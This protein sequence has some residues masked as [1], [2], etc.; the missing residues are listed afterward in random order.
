MLP[1]ISKAFA[2]AAN[3]IALESTHT[4]VHHLNEFVFRFFLARAIK[5]EHPK[6][7]VLPECR[8]IDLVIHHDGEIALLELKY[9][10]HTVGVD[11]IT[12]QGPYA[13]GYPSKANEKQFENSVEKLRDYKTAHKVERYAV[14]FYA[15]PISPE[16]RSYSA[17]Y[18][19]TETHFKLGIERRQIISP[20]SCKSSGHRC[21][22]LLF[23]V[24]A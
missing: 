5:L 3:H 7:I 15:D 4:P 13:K 9:L 16:R 19:S 17:W 11:P 14:V 1:L 10:V 22:G 23:A 12:R 20:F 21:S 6:A 18:E 2:E 8:K 24:H